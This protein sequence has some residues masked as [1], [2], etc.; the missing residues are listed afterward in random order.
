MAGIANFSFFK[1][2]QEIAWRK[3]DEENKRQ[4][5]ARIGEKAKI[6]SLISNTAACEQCILISK[7][8]DAVEQNLSDTS[9]SGELKN[10]IEE[11][12]SWTRLYVK[13][14]DPIK[15]LNFLQ[16]KKEMYYSIYD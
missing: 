9:Y 7:F 14:S 13:K 6:D 11:W 16:T 1:E 3:R 4:K 15:N 12:I 10:N 2:Q 5:Q 8:I